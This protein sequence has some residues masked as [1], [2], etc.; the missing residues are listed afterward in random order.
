MG[1]GGSESESDPEEELA[2]AGA[3]GAV[4]A[5]FL[6]GGSFSRLAGPLS[7]ESVAELVGGSGSGSGIFRFFKDAL[8][9]GFEGLGAKGAEPGA[10]A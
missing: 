1:A 10:S 9:P 5:G 3:A 6:L 4:A 8:L 2:V 7:P